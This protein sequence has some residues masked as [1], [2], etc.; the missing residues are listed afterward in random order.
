MLIIGRWFRVDVNETPYD[1]FGHILWRVS[2][3]LN[4]VRQM[5]HLRQPIIK[6][7]TIRY[8][9][10]IMDEEKVR[11]FLEEQSV[12]PLEMTAAFAGTQR[13]PLDEDMCSIQDP[14]AALEAAKRRAHQPKVDRRHIT[15]TSRSSLVIG[16]GSGRNTREFELQWWPDLYSTNFGKLTLRFFVGKVTK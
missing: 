16:E 2:P 15:V 6:D 4:A 5:R 11:E 10:K 14:L 8:S 7:W 3:P 12:V 13:V 9:Y 1:F